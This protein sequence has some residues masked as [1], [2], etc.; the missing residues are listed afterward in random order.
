MLLFKLPRVNQQFVCPVD[1][2]LD[3]L[4]Q[5][6]FWRS[7]IYAIIETG[8]KQYRVSAGQ[9]IEVDFLDA[10]DGT[11]VELDRVLFLSDGDKV[12]V[13]GPVVEGAKV[14]ATSQGDV[15]GAKTTSFKYK[16]K[17]RYHRKIGHHETY[18]RL[19]IDKIV[20]PGAPEEKAPAPKRTRR[21]KKEVTPDGA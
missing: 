3:R 15:R 9:I 7:D 10:L 18:T 6:P 2:R 1:I 4:I 12:T 17:T 8:G 13:G 11:Q 14:L 20:V 5:F 16:N 19:S 21:T